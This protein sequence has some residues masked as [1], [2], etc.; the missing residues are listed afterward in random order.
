MVDLWN[1][2][3]EELLWVPDW[4][5][6]NWLLYLGS[7]FAF[8]LALALLLFSKQTRFYLCMPSSRNN[9]KDGLMCRRRNLFLTI[10]LHWSLMSFADLCAN[11]LAIAD[12]L[13]PTCMCMLMMTSSSS[14]VELTCLTILGSRWLS[15]RPRVLGELRM[16]LGIW[17]HRELRRI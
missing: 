3:R 16:A 15:H 7:S 17:W 13:L 14:L 10:V 11:F 1:G 12:H 8:C 2:E 5:A 6:L 9:D 4:S